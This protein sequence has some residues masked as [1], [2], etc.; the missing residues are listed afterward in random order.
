MNKLDLHKRMTQI[1]RQV[2]REK[3]MHENLMICCDLS[4]ERMQLLLDEQNFL[5]TVYKEVK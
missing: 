2:E 5:A 1:K 4:L 3:L